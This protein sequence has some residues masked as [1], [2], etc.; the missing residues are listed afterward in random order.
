MKEYIGVQK[1]SKERHKLSKEIAQEVEKEYGKLEKEGEENPNL[2]KKEEKALRN[3]RKNRDIIVK[4]IDKNLGTAAIER[5]LYIEEV[6]KLLNDP[7]NYKKLEQDPTNATIKKLETLI[8]DLHKE[9][10]I[11]KKIAKKIA[12][13][14]EAKAGRFYALPKIHK[15][16]LGWRP[17]VAN[18]EHP[19][20]NMSKWISEVLKPTAKKALTSTENSTEI[21]EEVKKINEENRR[22]KKDRWIIVTADIENLYTNIPHQNGIESCIETLYKDEDN[23]LKP[24]SPLTM[25]ALMYNT[26]SNNIFEFNDKHYTQICGT[27]MGTSM[28]PA[29]AN[30]YLASKEEPWLE[31]TPLR[32]NMVCIKRYLD[33]IFIIY[34]NQ[35]ESLPNL[36]EELK[37]AYLPLKLNVDTGKKLPFL[38]LEIEIED[39]EI[40]YRL[41]RKPLNAKEIIPYNSCHPEACK[42]GTIIGEYKRIERLNS[43]TSD[44]KREEIKLLD[45]CLKQGY[46]YAEIKRIERKAKESKE[47]E[48]QKGNE[49]EKKVYMTLTYNPEME[50]MGNLV[51]ER[52]EE[53]RKEQETKEG[54]EIPKINLIA[55][56]KTQPNLKKILTRAKIPKKP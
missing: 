46:P 35:E 26:L 1:A 7:K 36:I 11:N 31:R 21:T 14:K 50:K 52:V 32:E 48:D 16:S 19:T 6:E 25:Q 37:Q 18:N 54:K 40:K 45:R 44:R 51:K 20:E 34:D 30:I 22:K 3:L 13:Y 4:P 24:K 8:A 2:T 5:S 42:R 12:P 15:P 56:Y 43:E 38:D 29:Y 41:Y 55:A 23:K 28:A 39:E 49:G 10:K 33:D 9:K 47:T 53:A 17:I 27:A